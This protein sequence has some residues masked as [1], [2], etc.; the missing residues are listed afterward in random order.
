M[1]PKSCQLLTFFFRKN[2]PFVIEI[3]QKP[4]LE[5]LKCC[6]NWVKLESDGRKRE[7]LPGSGG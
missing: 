6:I 2:F 3:P 1:F 7:A 4:R 5:L